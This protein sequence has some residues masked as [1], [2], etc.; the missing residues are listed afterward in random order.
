MNNSRELVR[1]H[2]YDAM[3]DLTIFEPYLDMAY[4]FDENK[5]PQ[6][7]VQLSNETKTR[8]EDEGG[9]PYL[10]YYS[11]TYDLFYFG[12]VQ[13]TNESVEEM[14]AE[15]NEWIERIKYRILATNLFTPV[16]TCD[17]NEGKKLMTFYIDD[18][19]INT[20][21]PVPAYE[22][23]IFAIRFN[24]TVRYRIIIQTDS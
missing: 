19:D 3:K 1:Q 24:G 7:V 17:Y 6:L 14:D 20:I 9:A 5:L 11:V 13:K 22:G 18:M 12:K 21:Q 2:I 15:I 10:N 4:N 23:D 8:R 16:P